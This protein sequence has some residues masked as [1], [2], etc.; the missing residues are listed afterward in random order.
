MWY[1]FLLYILAAQAAAVVLLSGW[2]Y[3][4][5]RFLAPYLRSEPPARVNGRR[6]KEEPAEIAVALPEAGYAAAW[7]DLRQTIAQQKSRELYRADVQALMLGLEQQYAD[8]EAETV[9]R[10][11]SGR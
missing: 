3:V 11:P 9:V 6:K 5:L 2:G 7:G 10:L 1:D 8:A 4:F